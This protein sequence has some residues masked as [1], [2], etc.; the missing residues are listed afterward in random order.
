MG[1]ADREPGAQGGVAETALL[2]AMCRAME[3]RREDPLVA[4]SFAPRFVNALVPDPSALR[5]F[6][7]DSI[8]T[9]IVRAALFDRIVTSEVGADERIG[10]VHLGAGFDM[11]PYRLEWPTGALI[12]EID[13][14]SVIRTKERLVI[15][16][17]PHCEVRRRSGDLAQPAH[18]RS[19]I[20]EHLAG[21]ERLVIMSEGVLHYMAS[22]Q[23]RSLA[24]ALAAIQ[25]PS[26]W[27]TDVTTRSSA[28]QLER[29]A[30]GR[31]LTLHPTADLADFVAEGWKLSEAFPL[32]LEGQREG[33]RVLGT[34]A[35]AG[36]ESLPDAVVI[37][38][39]HG[40]S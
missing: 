9:V 32:A 28:A 38:N 2:T 34:K 11:R 24:R 13:Q 37:L 33:R 4:D 16:E 29:A 17:T 31:S 8:D 10:I 7:G 3:Q 15:K 5:E 1:V 36:T 40:P 18:I 39:H 35:S 27:I 22:H 20:E 14:S 12:L 26:C 23:V 25:V 30:R 19:L 21:C 6:I